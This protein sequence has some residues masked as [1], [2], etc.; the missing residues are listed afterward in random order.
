MYDFWVVLLWSQELDAVILMDPVQL[1]IFYDSK[2]YRGPIKFR[3]FL[4]GS[5]VI[6][7]NS[8]CAYNASEVWL[9]NNKPFSEVTKY[10]YPH[11]LTMKLKFIQMIDLVFMS[12]E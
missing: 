11:I 9:A 7:V 10:C 4:Y 1:G 2:L 8:T 5:C 6:I 3:Q 12:A